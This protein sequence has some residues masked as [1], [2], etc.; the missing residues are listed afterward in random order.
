MPR[1]YKEAFSMLQV[2]QGKWLLSPFDGFD[3]NI[4]SESNI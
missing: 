3:A 1:I 2:S 4:G